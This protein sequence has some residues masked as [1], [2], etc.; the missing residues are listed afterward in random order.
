MKYFTLTIFLII[1]S[2]GFLTAQ[3]WSRE[4][5][6]WIK[7]VIEG[8]EELKLN[9]ET[10]K[11][12]EEGLLIVPQWMQGE[13]RNLQELIKDFENASRRDS[14]ELDRINPLSMPPAVFALY[15]LYIDKVDSINASQTIMLSEAEKERLRD[16]LPPG[17]TTIYVGNLGTGASSGVL[18]GNLDFNHALSMIFSSQ[19]RRLQY[20]KK[21][22]TAYKFYY[23]EGA[24][25]P[26]F[27][28]TESEKR[29]L[30]KDVQNRRKVNFKIKTSPIISNG[31]DD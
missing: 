8:K 4:D 13:K 7:N 22:A 11:A 15:V 17:E 6:I 18:V 29:R 1:T 9:E 24:I 20:N 14:T 19:Y 16:E 28:W 26:S 27:K 21:H 23:D 2:F 10:L 3:D 12:I 30:N 25:Q 5:S 31:I